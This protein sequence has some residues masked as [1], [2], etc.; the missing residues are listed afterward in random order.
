M[1]VTKYFVGQFSSKGHGA[2]Y[3]SSVEGKQ[4]YPFT[5]CIC[6]HPSS[7]HLNTPHGWECL[8]GKCACANLLTVIAVND[9]SPFKRFVNGIFGH[10]SPLGKGV[11]ELIENGGSFV[12]IVDTPCAACGED[13]LHL[14]VMS[15]EMGQW[16]AENARLVNTNV[17]FVCSKCALQKKYWF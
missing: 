2:W 12:Q 8:I 16:Y 14:D 5:I 6:G 10:R 15:L 13:S 9:F 4:N 1:S 7:E 17:W 3:E 11:K